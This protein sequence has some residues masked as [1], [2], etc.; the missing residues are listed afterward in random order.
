MQFDGPVP[1][2][3]VVGEAV[4]TGAG[5]L[6]VVVATAV[7]EAG[8]PAEAELE[9]MPQP[10]GGLVASEKPTQRPVSTVLE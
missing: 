4:M 10:G 6:S 3:G 2:G 1:K 7:F 9:G 8:E 5:P